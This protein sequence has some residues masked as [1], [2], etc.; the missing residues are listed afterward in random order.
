M[1]SFDLIISLLL[2]FANPSCLISSAPLNKLEVVN[3]NGEGGGSARCSLD[4]INGNIVY[5]CRK[6]ADDTKN[7]RLEY[8]GI[9]LV[10]AVDENTGKLYLVSGMNRNFLKKINCVALTSIPLVVPVLTSQ[11]IVS[12]NASVSYITQASSQ[13]VLFRNVIDRPYR[14]EA[15]SKR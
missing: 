14:T 3:V 1:V 13:S 12:A 7:T 4:A 15:A 9:G 11:S 8:F 2:N 6:E 5:L 10:R